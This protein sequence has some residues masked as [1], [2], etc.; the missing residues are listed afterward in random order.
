MPAEEVRNDETAWR[1][2]DR[3]GSVE[4]SSAS[5]EVV[6][7]SRAVLAASVRALGKLR[8]WVMCVHDN[9]VALGIIWVLGERRDDLE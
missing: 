9:A 5:S 7:P 3:Q 1:A 2:P 6:A 8:G 4:A